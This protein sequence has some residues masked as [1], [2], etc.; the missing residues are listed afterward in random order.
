M[1]RYVIDEFN[2]GP[3]KYILTPAVYRDNTHVGG[4]DKIIEVIEEKYF[5]FTG[6]SKLK[7]EIQ[8]KFL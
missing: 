7:P 1:V 4:Y 2:I 5:H 3:G 6:F 8:L